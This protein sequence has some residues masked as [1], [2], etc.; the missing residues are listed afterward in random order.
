MDA[1]S[2]RRNFYEAKTFF[3]TKYEKEYTTQK[4]PE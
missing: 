2:D 1:K 4:F 3:A